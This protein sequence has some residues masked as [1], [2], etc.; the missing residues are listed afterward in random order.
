MRIIDRKI[1]FQEDI[2]TCGQ[3][4]K[5]WRHALTRDS[6]TQRVGEGGGALGNMGW[7]GGDLAGGLKGQYNSKWV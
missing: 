3:N 2:I 7:M 5:T 4:D 1:F 6:V